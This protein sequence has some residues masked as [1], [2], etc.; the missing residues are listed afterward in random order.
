MPQ[1]KKDYPWVKIGCLKKNKV[2][3]YGAG[4]SFHW[5]SETLY[6]RYEVVPQLIVDKKFDE[7]LI[8][9]FIGS[10]IFVGILN[11]LIQGKFTIWNDDV[12][13]Q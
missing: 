10:L 5:F 2:I 1:S 9:F 8:G 7:T 12:R 3:V 13:D 11:Y 4:S 6:L